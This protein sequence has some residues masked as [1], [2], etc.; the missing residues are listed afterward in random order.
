MEE[1]LHGTVCQY[2][3][4]PACATGCTAGRRPA[5]REPVNVLDAPQHWKSAAASEAVRKG[6]AV[7]G[8]RTAA[9]A[10]GGLSYPGEV[11]GQ[12]GYLT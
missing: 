8:I 3:T 10:G 7:A 1:L 6:C 4:R 11:D 5:E 2:P 9:V 12:K